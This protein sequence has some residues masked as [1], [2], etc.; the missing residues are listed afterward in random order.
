MT[1]RYAAAKEHAPVRRGL[2][3]LEKPVQDAPARSN[4]LPAQSKHSLTG[5]TLIE[6]LVVIAIIGLLSAVVLAEL[7]TA[8]AKAN[9]AA[10]ASD[11]DAIRTAL[12]A[13]VNDAGSYPV[14]NTAITSAA[15]TDWIPDL[16]PKYIPTV[17]VDPV[18]EQ[19]P[20][21]LLF[22]YLSDGTNY[23]LEFSQQA[24]TTSDCANDPYSWATTPGGVCKIM[25]YTS[26]DY[27]NTNRTQF[28][29]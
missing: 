2:T 28:G 25:Y 22:Y 23:C 20:M 5:F 26:Y 6:L 16:A 3:P 9:D 8:R 12:Q 11:V 10:R 1:N 13:Y 4:S 17:P 27:C 7:D 21:G 24:F 18:N 19:N 15:G 14:A 29:S